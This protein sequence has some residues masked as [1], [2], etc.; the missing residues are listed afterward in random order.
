MVCFN[1]CAGNSKWRMQSGR[2]SDM[3][4]SQTKIK[5]KLYLAVQ[6]LQASICNIAIIAKDDSNTVLHTCCHHASEKNHWCCGVCT[7]IV[8]MSK[9]LQHS[10]PEL[11]K[12][13]QRALNTLPS[14]ADVPTLVVAWAGFCY[15]LRGTFKNISQVPISGPWTNHVL[16]V[17]WWQHPKPRQIC[18]FRGLKPTMSLNIEKSVESF[19]ISKIYI[20]I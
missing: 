7:W 18:K 8:V 20:Y 9:D 5:Q 1:V 6:I 12:N 14:H 19:N 17:D 11:C 13:D 2:L 4:F 15:T 10:R 16:Y 3:I